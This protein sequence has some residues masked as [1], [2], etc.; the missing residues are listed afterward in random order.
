[1]MAE[2]IQSHTFLS[3]DFDITGTIT[4]RGD[5][6]FDVD[7]DVKLMRTVEQMRVS[8]GTVTGNFDCS[9][10]GLRVLYGAPRQVG[11]TFS[12]SNNS[13]SSLMGGPIEVAGSYEVNRC[14]LSSMNG[15]AQKIGRSLICVG[16]HFADYSELPDKIGLGVYINWEPNLPLLARSL[17]ICF[18][19]FL[20]SLHRVLKFIPTWSGAP[21][22]LSM[23]S[24]SQ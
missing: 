3:E 5:G 24:P 23:C 6:K 4:V 9:N 17:P 7:G 20:K 10:Q 13:L 21:S 2:L 16:N 12:C 14:R 18:G 15:I 11:G 8:F 1:M 19:R 22:R